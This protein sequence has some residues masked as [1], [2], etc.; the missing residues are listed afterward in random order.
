VLEGL[1]GFSFPRGAGLCTRYVTEIHCVRGNKAFK[2]I[3]IIPHPSASEAEHERLWEFSHRVEADDRVSLAQIF[4]DVG[5]CV[6]NNTM[7][8]G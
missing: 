4:E 7:A 6:R 8:V 5:Y 1:T 3:S 2:E